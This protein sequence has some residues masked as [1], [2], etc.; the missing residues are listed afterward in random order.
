MI[1]IK[2]N[3]I[4]FNKIMNNKRL[5]RVLFDPRAYGVE[6][7]STV[8]LKKEPSSPSKRR[9]KERYRVLKRDGEER[10]KKEERKE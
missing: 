4:H 1:E 3:L 7:T 9:V 8:R 6:E 10:K 2:E 5:Y